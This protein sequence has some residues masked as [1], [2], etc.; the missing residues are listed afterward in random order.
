M[1]KVVKLF[2][3][4]YERKMTNPSP[5]N[6]HAFAKQ[7]FRVIEEFKLK[8]GMTGE[9]LWIVKDDTEGF[10][11]QIGGYYGIT[12]TIDDLVKD[13]GYN[14][15][16]NVFFDYIDHVYEAKDNKLIPLTYEEYL[17]LKG[18]KYESSIKILL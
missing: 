9:D 17:D 13:V 1:L 7:L 18:I 8:H 10:L 15:P 14:I 16:K 6:D 3:K 12:F 4:Q 11:I 2:F 5:E